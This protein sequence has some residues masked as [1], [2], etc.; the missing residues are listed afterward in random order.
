MNAE[1]KY[2]LLFMRDDSRVRRL[3]LSPVWLRL[4]AYLLVL[5]TL[6]AGFGVWGSVHFWQAAQALDEDR[7]SLERQLAEDR[8]R[9]ERLENV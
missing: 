6:A 8:L 1:G 2:S 9:L 3:R 5:Q 7:A 4:G